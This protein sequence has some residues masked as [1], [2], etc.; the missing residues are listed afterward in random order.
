MFTCI[1]LLDPTD[2]SE[3]LLAVGWLYEEHWIIR[4]SSLNPFGLY[5]NPWIP[6]QGI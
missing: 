2:V 3:F 4:A 1:T 6:C 5:P